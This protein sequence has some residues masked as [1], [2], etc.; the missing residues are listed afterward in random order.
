MAAYD[1]SDFVIVLTFVPSLEEAQTIARALV[2][3][4]LAAC[5]NLLPSVQSFYQWQ[6]EMCESAEVGVLIKTR[7]SLTDEVF[8]RVKTLHSYDVPALSAVRLEAVDAHF[9][10]WLGEQTLSP[11]LHA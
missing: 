8:A 11:E 1:K 2:H 5:V 7:A 10:Q 3:D 9:A 6:G 4:K